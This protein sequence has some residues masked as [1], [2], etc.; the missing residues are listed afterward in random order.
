MTTFTE[1]FETELVVSSSFRSFKILISSKGLLQGH[2]P[3]YESG[4]LAYSYFNLIIR[5]MQRLTKLI[6]VQ[7]IKTAI[8][9][10][11]ALYS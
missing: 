11:E 8:A 9:H 2:L 3:R 4:Y 1:F 7:N 10:L 6:R 5:P